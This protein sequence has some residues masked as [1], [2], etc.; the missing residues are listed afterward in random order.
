MKKTMIVI[1]SPLEKPL[2]CVLLG[3][4]PCVL[5]LQA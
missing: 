3:T 1:V 2:M 5:H 4:N